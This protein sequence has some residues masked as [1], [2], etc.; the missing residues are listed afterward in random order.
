MIEE[1]YFKEF[2][3]LE[4][5]RLLLRQISLKDA[6]DIQ[7][8]RSNEQ[9]MSF[10]DS[11]RHTSVEDAEN[12]IEEGLRIYEA[13][14]GLFWGLEEKAT[15]E[16][17]GDLSF[18]KIDKKNCRA[19]IGY[20]LKPEFW[21]S[22]YMKEAMLRIFDFGFNDLKLHSLEAN[23]NPKNENSRGI[24]LRLGFK[25]EAYFRENFF[26]NGEFLDSEIYSL[27]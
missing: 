17:I 2:P 13:K 10:M 8:I 9:V 5:E 21:G 3:R 25:K 15:G 6:P 11:H 23:I 22:G 12:F 7:D 14:N 4:T 18:W 1:K 24:L 20:T 16:F 26:F 19:E 27:L